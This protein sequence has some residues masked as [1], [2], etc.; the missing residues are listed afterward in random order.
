MKFKQNCDMNQAK[1]SSIKLSPK[2]DRKQSKKV[3]G[4]CKG[5][6]DFDISL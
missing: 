3:K 4:N 1:I 6:E 5:T 2:K